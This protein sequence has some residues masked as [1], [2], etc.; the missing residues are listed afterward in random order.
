MGSSPPKPDP[1]I[2]EAAMKQADI[3]MQA[4]QDANVWAQK[5]YEF[6]KVQHGDMMG[7]ADRQMQFA[8]QAR[9]DQLGIANQQMDLSRQALAASADF[10]Q[11]QLDLG[12]SHLAF[13][14]GQAEITNKWAQQDRDRYYNTFV[15]LQ[16]AWIE[17]ANNFASPERK[18]MAAAEA[19]ADVRQQFEMGR[20]QNERRLSAMGVA[21]TSGRY[22]S[23]SNRDQITEN[24]AVA[25]AGNAARRQTDETGRNMRLS[26]IG[27]GQGLAV[28]PA[29]S[30]GLSNAAAN[31]GFGGAMQG[32]ASAQGM[33]LQRIGMAGNLLGAAGGTMAGANAGFAGALGQSASM[34]GAGNNAMAGA[35]G[36]AGNMVMGGA[37]TAMAGQQNLAG[38]LNNQYQNELQSWNARQAQL[39][40]I[41]GGIGMG[42]GFLSS[43]DSKKNKRKPV[44]ALGAL[45]D[46]PVE[47]WEYKQGHG[48]G[49][50]HI[51]PYAEDFQ[52]ATG[53]GTGKSISV[54]D[55]IGV[56][57]G[58]VQ[59]LA[60]KVDKQASRK[61]AAA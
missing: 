32:N 22:Q 29:T 18:A 57:M 4:Q 36:S 2:G 50:R 25:G 11:G 20:G 19:K 1:K 61:H 38:I 16:D 24:L 42:L 58:A 52:K 23:S 10:A 44:S 43:K 45:K 13:M 53:L 21:P 60:D 51:G 7:L 41:F 9:Q 3:A 59:E 17:E 55:A 56:T 26:A 46:M 37:G 31:A 35:I 28:N 14:K 30:I 40:S 8:E 49:Q 12:R 33:E 6:G 5:Q 27:M 47:E 39:G 48:D 34:I 15:P 54:I